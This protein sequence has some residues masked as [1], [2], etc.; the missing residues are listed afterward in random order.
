MSATIDK[1]AGDKS[2][3]ARSVDQLLAEYDNA[4]ACVADLLC[5]RHDPEATA[6][7]VVSEGDEGALQTNAL[8]YGELKV[9]SEKVAAALSDLGVGQGDAV[10]TLMG[11][12]AELVG[13][14]LGIWRLGAVY[15]PMFT[16]FA[17]PAIEM[18]LEGSGAKV[19]VSDPL[20]REKIGGGD[21][22]VVVAGSAA[23]ASAVMQDGDLLLDELTARASWGERASARMGGGG[24]MV[25]LYTSGTTG[26]PKGVVIPVRALAS[27]HQYMEIGLDM[28]PEDVFWNCA[29]PGW[30]YGLYYGI[31]GPMALGLPN[32]LLTAPYSPERALRVFDEC[33]VT[34][35]AAAPT[36]YRTIRAHAADAAGPARLRCASSAGEP[37]TPEIIE[38]GKSFLG[39]EVRDHYGQTEHGMF[40]VNPWHPQYR[41]DLHPGSMGVSLPGWD[42]DVLDPVGDHPMDRAAAQDSSDDRMGR[43]A[44][45]M[46]ASPLKWF[47]GYLD[48]PEKTAERFSADGRWYLTG[49][50]G[51]RGQD[52]L[53]YFASRDDDVVIMAGYRI[54]PFDVESVLVQDPEVIEAAV[55]GVPDEVRGEVLESYVVLREGIPGTDA[56]EETTARLQ[57]LVKTRFAAHAYPRRIHYV[58]ELPKTPSG[59]IQRFLLRKERAAQS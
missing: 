5:D 3:T 8:T 15:V 32:I 6:F 53:F 20:Q 35:F 2:R 1:S 26:R 11:K 10:A 25:V 58:A 23:A 36:V 54:G 44:I 46:S 29:D 40:I 22:Q 51:K 57:Q 17:W 21:A 19:I 52:G 39:S 45:D 24:T 59:K 56:A 33:G 27:F 16:A 14:I 43:V 9:H 42:S 30:A 49:D 31:M 47:S 34:N 7:T 4:D 55:I 50:A 37:L 28:H 12:S 13:V 41:N 48:A 38:W 18:R